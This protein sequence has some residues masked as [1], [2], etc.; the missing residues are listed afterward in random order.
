MPVHD[1]SRVDAGLFHHFHQEWTMQLVHALNRRLPPG[2]S[3]LAEQH[4]EGFVPDVLT[5]QRRAAPRPKPVG[6]G[7]M[8]AE[9]RVRH[10]FRGAAEQY[11]DRGNR[12]VVRH[13]LGEVIAALEV[14]SPGNK[15]S[16]YRLD[17]FIEKTLEFLQHGVH[18]LVLDL[19]PPGPRDPSG[20]HALLWP[21]LVGNAE[22]PAPGL[23]LTMAAYVAEG[24][25]AYR[26]LLEDVAIGTPL[27]DMPLYLDCDVHVAVPLE[28][29]YVQ[30]F[31]NCP[32]D[33]RAAVE[34]RA[35]DPL[36]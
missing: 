16:Q 19:F 15:S 33:F 26:A 20:L 22:L 29:A 6:G 21:A 14:V 23:P 25:G 17:R 34:G 3:A 27:P 4:V 2:Y 18:L 13:R 10:V 12:V 31:A 1:W 7:A 30:A 5:V 36:P 9:P 35:P 11:A 32:A 8:L 28:A 24:D